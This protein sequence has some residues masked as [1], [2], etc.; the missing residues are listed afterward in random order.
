MVP[1]W[2]SITVNEGKFRQVRKMTAVFGYVTF[3]SCSNR[4][5]YISMIYRL[6]VKVEDFQIE[7]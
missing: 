2:A 6:G 4:N 5:L 1:S 7:M 3:G